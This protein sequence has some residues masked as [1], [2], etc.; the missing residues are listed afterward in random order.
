MRGTSDLLFVA[1]EVGTVAVLPDV[2]GITPF[3]SSNGLRLLVRARVSGSD[4]SPFSLAT[5]GDVTLLARVEERRVRPKY[6]SVGPVSVGEGEMTSGVRGMGV[7]RE[8]MVK[9]WQAG[10]QGRIG[11]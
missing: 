6:P 3:F 7:R 9:E 1:F 2:K 4:V 10:Y 11:V 8:D 5:V